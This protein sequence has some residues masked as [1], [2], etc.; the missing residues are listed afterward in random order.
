[1]IGA[2][3]PDRRASRSREALT[4]SGAKPARRAAPALPRTTAERARGRPAPDNALSPP[5][6][7]QPARRSAPP[8]RGITSPCLATAGAGARAGRPGVY[9]RQAVSR[10]PDPRC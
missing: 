9:G 3:R 5:E 4:S 7:K 8:P 10:R 2:A 1:M 6:A